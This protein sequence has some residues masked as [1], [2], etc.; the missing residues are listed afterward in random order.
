MTE[1]DPPTFL[2]LD[3]DGGDFVLEGTGGLCGSPSLLRLEC[4]RIAFLSGR[5]IKLGDL[6]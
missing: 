1:L 6:L 3:V 2:G 4:K 5:E